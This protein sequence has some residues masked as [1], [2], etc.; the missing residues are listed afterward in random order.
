MPA[1]VVEAFLYP[2]GVSDAI[3]G[4]FW[5]ESG[6]RVQGTLTLDASSYFLELRGFCF[7]PHSLDIQPGS[8]AVSSDPAAIASDFAPRTIFGD[9]GSKGP[10]TLLRA[11]M[12]M[13]SIPFI[14]GPIVQRFTGSFYALDAHIRGDQHEIQGIWWTWDLSRSQAGWLGDSPVD[15]TDGPLP[16]TL[17]SWSFENRPGLVIE[18]SDSAEL[19]VVRQG[20]MTAITQFL[21]LWTHRELDLNRVEIQLEDQSWYEC[22]PP[23]PD[24]GRFSRTRLLPL[25]EVTLQLFADWLPMGF[26]L[27]P[28]PYIA[29][30]TAGVLQIDAQAVATSLEGLH[31][32]LLGDRRPFAPLSIGS[33]KRATRVARE[34]GVRKLV[35][36][37]FADEA[38]AAKLFSEALNHVDQPSY[39]QRVAELAVTVVDIA[40]GLC[41]PDPTDWVK[42]MKAIR[43]EQSHQLLDRFY[44]EEVTQYHIASISGRWVLALRILMEFVDPVRLGRAL[45]ESQTFAFALAN[46][47]SE[48]YWAG[49]SCLQTFRDAAKR[50]AG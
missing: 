12:D 29:S 28:L 4:T 41:G 16:G 27:D 47:D 30:A 42:S 50:P 8:V 22:S 43:N 17:K 1:L 6:P 23:K 7:N 5:V 39:Q 10:V 9:L 45:R 11:H 21:V 48:R 20:V 2:C 44:E 40:P 33:V 49:F 15:V 31:R 25:D 35:E 3:D 37:G 34:A 26:R 24:A 38:L 18:L 14:L 36:S 46:I 19:R 32:R 13:D